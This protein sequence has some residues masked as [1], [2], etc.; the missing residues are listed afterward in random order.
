[1]SNEY[2]IQY[3][4]EQL[5][6]FA[7]KWDNVPVITL[8]DG[9]G[10]DLLS[11]TLG[12]GDASCVYAVTFGDDNLKGFQV[13]PMSVYGMNAISVMQGYDIEWQMN[14]APLNRRCFARL[15]YVKNAVTA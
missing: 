2:N 14:I 1:V 5:G 7:G 3:T 4:P 12:A 9:K 8:K 15:N 10:N 13:A 11:T 6:T